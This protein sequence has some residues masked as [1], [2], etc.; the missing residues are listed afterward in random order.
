MA[1]E[2]N[3]GRRKRLVRS[4]EFK[5]QAVQRMEAGECIS[6]LSRELEVGRKV[7]YQWRE[8]FR[9]EGMKGFERRPVRARRDQVLETTAGQI[10]ALERKVGQQA[11]LIDFLQKAFKRVE[12]SRRDNNA[13]GA[14][15]STGRS[16]A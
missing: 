10:A 5:H 8:R 15:A 16:E 7:L 4:V 3:G 12:D 13:S 2:T 11:L 9:Q 1:K 14:K 6:A